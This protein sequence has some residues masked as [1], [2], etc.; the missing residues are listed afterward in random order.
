MYS[1]KEYRCCFP[2]TQQLQKLRTHEFRHKV[3]RLTVLN[4]AWMFVMRTAKAMTTARMNIV[5]HDHIEQD[6]CF[7]LLVFNSVHWS[8]QNISK[9]SRHPAL[10]SDL[11]GNFQVYHI[12]HIL[13]L[14]FQQ[15]L[16]RKMKTPLKVNAESN[17]LQFLLRD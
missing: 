12:F 14:N 4:E 6:R 17:R 15:L 9:P 16:K 5:K 3:S 2:S 7:L 11:C 13:F 1:E 8:W 10:N